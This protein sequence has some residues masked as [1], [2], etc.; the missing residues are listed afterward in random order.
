MTAIYS[1]WRSFLCLLSRNLT[2][3][4]EITPLTMPVTNG[5][6][7]SSQTI[8]YAPP[9]MVRYLYN[10][11]SLSRRDSNRLLTI[12]FSLDEM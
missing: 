7:T 1:A 11:I 3:Y 12:S 9:F 2:M 4:A 8:T 5:I 10:W 6:T